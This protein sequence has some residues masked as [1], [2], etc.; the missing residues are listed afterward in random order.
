MLRLTLPGSAAPLT[1]Y[2]AIAAALAP[3]GTGL[4]PLDL[5]RAP[6]DVRAL[7]GKPGLD[8]DEAE[9]V[10]AHFLMPRARLLE[11]LGA[12]GRAPHVAGGGALETLDTTHDVPY[13]ELYQVD[14]GT[15]YSRFDRFHVN[16]SG[17]DGTAVDEFMQVLAGAGVRY[18]QRLSGGG[19]L[20][21]DLSCPEPS[22]GWLLAYDGGCHHIGSFTAC[23]PGSKILMQ[24]IGP[25]RWVMRYEDEG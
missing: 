8:E 18:L 20:V 12:A 19:E 22:S 11:V 5:G 23:T 3:L 13:P 9:L 25:A 15:D 16:I 4:W 6:A 17:A 14:A 24:I 7:V 10:R 2:G 1:S 21:L